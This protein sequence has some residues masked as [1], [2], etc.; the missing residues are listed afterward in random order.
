MKVV[1]EALFL[2][3]WDKLGFYSQTHVFLHAE[4]FVH[5]S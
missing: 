3:L 4:M 2:Q 5:Y 1:Q